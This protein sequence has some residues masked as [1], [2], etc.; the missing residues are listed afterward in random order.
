VQ[1]VI[2]P[3]K[4][5]TRLVDSLAACLR[6]ITEMERCVALGIE[7]GSNLDVYSPQILKHF[8]G[9]SGKAKTAL[10][11]AETFREWSISPAR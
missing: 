1:V 10:T 7:N 6:Q 5:R 2:L 11:A 9:A 4:A 8:E 3:V